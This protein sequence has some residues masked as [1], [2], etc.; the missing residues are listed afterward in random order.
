MLSQ[1][2]D[3]YLANKTANTFRTEMYEFVNM[4]FS[5]EVHN[6]MNIL[7]WI[8]FKLLNIS[9]PNVYALNLIK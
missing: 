8:R 4:A 7:R 6:W 9:H 5:F 3:E 2:N 1:T